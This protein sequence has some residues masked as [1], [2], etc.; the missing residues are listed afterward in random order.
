MS[1]KPVIRVPYNT[2]D[3]LTNLVSGLGGAKDKMASTLYG[4]RFVDRQQLDAAYRGDWIARKV[5]DIPAFDATRRWRAWQAEDDQIE[6]LEE[7]ERRLNVQ[8]KVA[9]AL[10]R[11]RLYGGAA[12]IL[13]MGDDPSTELN[14]ETVKADG[15]QYLHVANRWQ[16]TIPKINRDVMSPYFGEPDMYQVSSET[17]GMVNVHPS[18][19]V[20]IVGA[21]LPDIDQ[22]PDGWGDSVLMA[23][24]TAI[25]AA[26]ATNENLAQLVYEAKVDTIKIPDLMLQLATAEYRDLLTDRFTLANVQKSINNTLMLD[27]NED[28]STRTVNFAGMPDIIRAYLMIATAAADIPATRFLGQSPQGLS[29]TGESDTRNYYDRVSS[30]QEMKLTP[31]MSRLDEVIIRSA[32]GDRPDEVYYEWRSL[33]QMT[34]KEKAEIA[35]L[36]ADVYQ[37]DV[38][39]GLIS[40][41]AL[42]MGRENQLVEDGFYPGFEAALA[43]AVDDEPDETDPEVLAQMALA[44]AGRVPVAPPVAELPVGDAAPRTLYIRRDVLNAADLRSWAVSQGMTVQDGLHVTVIHTQTPLDWIKVG[45]ADE[46]GDGNIEVVGGPRLMERF[47]DAVVL[48][49]A[50][51]RLTWRHEDIKRM[52]AHTDY[53]D[54]QPH[55]TISW[56]FD[57]D[58]S[59][60][61]P[62]RG[63][64]KLGPEIFEE[65]DDNW[66]AK[67]SE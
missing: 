21:E 7:T 34:D 6:K 51:S 55:V 3:S 16:L 2:R 48:Q 54:Y 63:A 37:I 49:F 42:R 32:L 66:R 20:R 33:W 43:D 4:L 25:K 31:A 29:S 59:A 1:T 12:L 64:I 45:N 50:S 61:E 18:R 47:G 5:V 9:A 28:W 56:K 39:T 27:A 38:N 17:V 46:F 44:Q 53:P 22:S 23:V 62:Y 10:I 60:I 24:D 19:V 40:D 67:V 58:I 11:A 15:L 8:Q 57:G 52:G 30:E 65:V 36:K 14:P 35:K 13:G 26:S 41:D